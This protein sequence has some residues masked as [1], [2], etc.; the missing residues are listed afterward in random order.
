MLGQWGSDGGSQ[1]EN[2]EERRMR[3]R[4]GEKKATRRMVGRKG[5]RAKETRERS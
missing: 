1:R 3:R 2:D 4:C 5:V